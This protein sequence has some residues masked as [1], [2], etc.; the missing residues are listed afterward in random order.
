MRQTAKIRFRW[1]FVAEIHLFQAQIINIHFE[2]KA[3]V[4]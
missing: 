1:Q 3:K 4:V 2:E